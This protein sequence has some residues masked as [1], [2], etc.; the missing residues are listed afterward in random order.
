MCLL[1]LFYVKSKFHNLCFKNT[2]TT[3]TTN[4]NNNN[5]NNNNILMYLIQVSHS[6][7][8]QFHE[9]L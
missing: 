5:N 2:T 9:I 3:T 4:N 6:Y 8:Q 1:R 7:Q